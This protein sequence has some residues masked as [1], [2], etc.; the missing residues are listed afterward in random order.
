MK[1]SWTNGLDEQVATDIKAS[2]AGSVLVRRRLAKLLEDKAEESLR[3]SRNKSNYA[4]SAWAY[5]QADSRGYERALLEIIE[6][7]K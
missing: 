7:I 3:E 4:N 2:Y 5:Q 1:K 6:L